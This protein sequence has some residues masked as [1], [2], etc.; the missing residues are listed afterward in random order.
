MNIIARRVDP[1]RDLASLRSRFDRLFSDHFATLGDA[2]GG[3]AFSSSWVPS[4]DVLENDSEIRLRAEL[5]GMNEDDVEITL[6]NNQLTLQG[7]KKFELEENEGEYRRVESR[8]G[9]FYRRFSIPAT[10]DQ[11]K[12][13]AQFSNGVLTVALPKAEAAKP[14]RIPV[15]LN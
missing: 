6:E 10:V 1:F 3:E 15:R 2:D 8:Y 5:P 11:T 13:D 9:K 12:I 4:I 14:K 7:E